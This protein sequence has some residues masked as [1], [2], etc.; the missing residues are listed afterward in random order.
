M[1]RSA[2][3]H[4]VHSRFARAHLRTREER[5]V[6]FTLVAQLATS[7]SAAELAQLK[8]LDPD[9]VVT[10]LNRYTVAGIVEAIDAPTGRRFRWR[11]DMAYL[12]GAE[13][14]ATSTVD[15][16]CGMTVDEATPHRVRDV[17]GRTRLFCSAGC[18]SMFSHKSATSNGSDAVDPHP[19]TGPER[20]PGVLTL[21]YVERCPGFPLLAER[22]RAALARSWADR[23]LVRARV[24]REV[25]PPAAG[26]AG[27]PTLLVNGVDPFPTTAPATGLGCRYYRT[28]TGLDAA[29]SVEQLVTALR[30][31]STR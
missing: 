23:L 7:W 26:F 31:R 9:A 27:S 2:P 12:Y 29:P 11:S 13:P 21:L 22:L 24:I 28:E 25:Q 20:G 16:V 14:G 17:H 5:A 1:T 6:Y 3:W 15:P 19:V 8:H 10:V 30:T 4:D 18:A